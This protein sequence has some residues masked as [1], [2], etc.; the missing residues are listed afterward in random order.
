VHCGLDALAVG[1][2]VS[3]AKLELHRGKLFWTKLELR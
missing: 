1:A 3:E 2:R